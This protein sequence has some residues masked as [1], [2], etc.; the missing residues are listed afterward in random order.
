MATQIL[1]GAVR[2]ALSWA[3]S[4]S[5]ALASAVTQPSLC[6]CL[7]LKQTPVSGLVGHWVGAPLN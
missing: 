1:P 6:L 7:N 5:R 2:E 3:L 4:T